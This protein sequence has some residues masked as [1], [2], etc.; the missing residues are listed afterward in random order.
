MSLRGP[1]RAL[2]R[3]VADIATASDDDILLILESLGPRDRA[4]V[5]VLLAELGGDVEAPS[6]L[7][8]RADL[9][10][11][12]EGLSPALLERLVGK[13]AAPAG[14]SMTPH[15]MSILQA[16]ATTMAPQQ[17]PKSSVS[18][19]PALLNRIFQ[20]SGHSQGDLR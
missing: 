20:R 19:G 5:E 17:P 16:C 6:S 11:W 13:P 10:I 9:K 14:W 15:A 8:E 1:D 7:L 12:S 3:L 4:R 2:R 18:Q